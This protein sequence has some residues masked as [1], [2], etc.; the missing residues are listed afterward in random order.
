M[1]TC[2]RPTVG[3]PLLWAVWLLSLLAAPSPAAAGQEVVPPP[4]KDWPQPVEDQPII[5]Y[6]LVDQLEYRAQ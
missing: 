5:G 4:P 2:A 3:L 6:F 1:M